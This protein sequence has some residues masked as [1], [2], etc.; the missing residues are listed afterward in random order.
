[1]KEKGISFEKILHLTD[2]WS[3]SDENEGREEY[4]KLY[5]HFK[6]QHDQNRQ[7]ISRKFEPEKNVDIYIY[8][9]QA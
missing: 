9:I 7:K 5:K 3:G 6:T 2:I 4:T 8:T 1:M